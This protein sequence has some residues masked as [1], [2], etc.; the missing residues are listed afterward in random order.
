M[1]N[2]FKVGDLV[3]F[4]APNVF[5][6]SESRYKSPG[7]II[8]VNERATQKTAYKIVWADGK[9]TTEWEAYIKHPQG[10]EK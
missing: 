1:T 4:S 8:E 10:V 3:V 2:Q 5:K 9:T 6:Q 7:I